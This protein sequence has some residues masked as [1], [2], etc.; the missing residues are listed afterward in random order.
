[1]G[2]WAASQFQ[3]PQFRSAFQCHERYCKA[4]WLLLSAILFK[5]IL[6]L[7]L[8]IINFDYYWTT[9]MI[10]IDLFDRWRVQTSHLL[11]RRHARL[12]EPPV[13]GCWNS[14]RKLG[15][16]EP[17]V[18]RIKKIFCT[19]KQKDKNKTKQNKKHVADCHSRWTL[20]PPF[21]RHRNVHLK[22]NLILIFVIDR[23][24]HRDLPPVKQMLGH[25]WEEPPDY[26][27]HFVWHLLCLFS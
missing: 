10:I 1:M 27:S 15:P 22:T 20:S 24:N 19:K 5:I 21:C 7:I 17:H 13:V 2:G 14:G 6:K 23:K 3:P 12:A 11:S 26:R 9:W 4:N 16:G 8:I 25:T 18:L